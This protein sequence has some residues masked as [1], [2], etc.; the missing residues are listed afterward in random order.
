MDKAEP[1]KEL[2]E[3]STR[4]SLIALSYRVPENEQPAAA[5]P[6]NTSGE[7]GCGNPHFDGKEKLRTELISIS[8]SSSPDMEVR[9]LS[10][11]EFDG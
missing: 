7:N 3:D 2:S 8:Y 4:E 5:S 9:P 6:K 10:P 1:K 11:V